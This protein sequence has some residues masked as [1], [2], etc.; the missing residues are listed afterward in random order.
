MLIFHTLRSSIATVEDSFNSQP[1][2]QVPLP[3]H[4][5]YTLESTG[6]A[7]VIKYTS[8]DTISITLPILPATASLW[9]ASGAKSLGNLDL[10]L[11]TVPYGLLIRAVG[12]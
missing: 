1:D 3:V 6:A 7:T 8:S 4:I 9:T 11:Y 5:N 10:H 12:A 2:L